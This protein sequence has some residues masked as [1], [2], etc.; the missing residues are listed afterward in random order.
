MNTN[1][2]LRIGQ[3]ADYLGV[4]TQTIRNYTK[5]G[6]IPY[7]LTPGGNRLFLMS[8][9]EKIKPGFS[10]QNVIAFYIRSSSGNKES[11]ANQYN[12]LEQRYGT[13]QYYY[14][15]SA[16]GLNENR[17]GLLKLLAD[18][19]KGLFNILIIT[20]QDRLSRFGFSYLE[21]LLTEYN[22]KIIIAEDLQEKSIYDELMQDFMS[23][24]ASFS[25][26]FYKIRSTENKKRLLKKAE[27][28]LEYGE[29][30]YPII[31]HQ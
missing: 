14:K 7:S 29:N 27:K 19:K 3:A 15:D 24:I 21:L 5:D 16:S 20:N 13:P 4:T 30:I 2:Y 9:L 10:N 17:K 6:K 28:E 18:A 1:K 22:V 31:K 26:K 25:G 23:L 12:L 11:M 8:D